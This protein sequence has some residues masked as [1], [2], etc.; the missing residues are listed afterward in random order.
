[1]KKFC[2]ISL[3]R[4]TPHLITGT[5]LRFVEYPVTHDVLAVQ[6]ICYWSGKFVLKQDFREFFQFNSFS[7]FARGIGFWH[8]HG[9]PAKHIFLECKIKIYN[10]VLPSQRHIVEYSDQ[11][12]TTRTETSWV[13]SLE[14]PISQSVHVSLANFAI[15]CYVNTNYTLV[16]HLCAI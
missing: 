15:S 13:L 1:M 3:A 10:Q 7:W 6:G 5:Q 12:N 14:I 2:E 4:Q 11:G 8:Y 9:V 16:K